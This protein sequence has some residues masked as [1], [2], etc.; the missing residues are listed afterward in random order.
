M[1][2]LHICEKVKLQDKRTDEVLVPGVRIIW[3]RKQNQVVC[4]NYSRHLTYIEIIILHGTTR[5]HISNTHARLYSNCLYLYV[6]KWKAF[7]P[8]RLTLTHSHVR[9]LWLYPVYHTK[10]PA[11]SILTRGCAFH[12]LK[13]KKFCSCC[14]G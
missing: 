11:S 5:Q 4:K 7:V 6:W 8:F 3:Y 10:D 12:I 14:N 9:K 2:A 13:Y 1:Y